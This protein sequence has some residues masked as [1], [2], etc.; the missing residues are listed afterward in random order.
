MEFTKIEDLSPTEKENLNFLSLFL[1]SAK[2]KLNPVSSPARSRGGKMWALGWRKAMV[3]AQLIGRCIFQSAADK[4]MEDYDNL[5][6]TSD[7]ASN[8][9]GNMFKSMADIPY[10]RNRDLMKK[11]NIPSFAHLSFNDPLSEGDCSP[12]LTYTSD[13]FFNNPHEDNQDISNF[14]FTLFFL[15]TKF[16]IDFTKQKGVV[17]LFWALKMENTAPFLPSKIIFTL[18]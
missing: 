12:H 16:G 8:I 4:N 9:L 5:M 17:K 13:G 1:H 6:K 11:N 15:T 2:K 3:T 18:V 7:R 10:E 14:D